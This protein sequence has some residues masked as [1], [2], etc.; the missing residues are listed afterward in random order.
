MAKM[1]DFVRDLRLCP[2]PKKLKFVPAD[3]FFDLARWR[4][5]GVLKRSDLLSKNADI[6]FTGTPD[7]FDDL[8]YFRL[9]VKPDKIE[10]AASSNSAADWALELLWQLVLQAKD[11][12]L[13]CCEIEDWPDLPIRGFM[14]DISRG[15]VPTLDE[16][17]EILLFLHRNR[18]NHLQLYVEHTYAF[19]NH[20]KVWENA[21]PLDAKMLKQIQDWCDA[22]EIELV[23]NLNSFG[24]VERWL[25]HKKYNALA[26]CPD[27][28]FHDLANEWRPAGTFAPTQK[29]ADFMGTLYD[30][31]LP[32][33]HSS[34]FN[35]GGDEPWELGLGKSKN[36]CEKKGKRAV[37]V[38]H[39]MRLIKKAEAHEKSVLFWGDV[40][41]ENNDEPLPREMLERTVP[42]I[43]GYEPNHPFEEQCARVVAALPDDRK[44]YFLLAPGTSNWLSF[45]GRE[46]A[47]EINIRRAC[48]AAKKFQAAGTLLTTWG[49]KGY[50][51]SFGI[52]LPSIVFAGAAAWNVNEPIGQ[53]ADIKIGLQTYL[54]VPAQRK[55]IE[56][57]VDLL[58]ALGEIDA[59]FSKQIPNRSLLHCAFFAPETALDDLIKDVP[60]EE[61]EK[62]F[63]R[64]DALSSQFFKI[65]FEE[66]NDDNSENVKKLLLDILAAICFDFQAVVRIISKKRGVP[67]KT[68]IDE[69]L[70]K[71]FAA[72]WRSRDCEGGLDEALSYFD[73]RK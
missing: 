9:V 26:E 45:S 2:Y 30:E 14:L 67:V 64:I 1:S 73:K 48:K 4:K 25:K 65:K 33:F 36:L 66:C 35:I 18:Y 69:E 29:S 5:N 13:P 61:C 12:Q 23:P 72:A 47:A 7:E 70:K 28:F 50:F 56:K 16:F 22:M 19:K 41:L 37:Y 55:T 8:E 53:N 60:A 24:H 49:D 3:K 42:V 10:V 54:D 38:E 21:S 17:F 63:A 34:W 68:K 62:V 31:Y 15:R 39:M 59:M 46:T 11:E 32:Q 43:W 57:I 51:N 20:K 58:L 44:H 52:A 40:L 27:G 6:K 71:I